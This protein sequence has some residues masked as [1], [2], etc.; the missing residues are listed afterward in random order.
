MY[1]ADIEYVEMMADIWRRKAYQPEG[2]EN[3]R[4]QL[5]F[6]AYEIVR[7][8]YDPSITEEEKNLQ[9]KALAMETERIAP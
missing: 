8:F 1:Y 4:K 2:K 3:V 7:I 9:I 5:F 6:A